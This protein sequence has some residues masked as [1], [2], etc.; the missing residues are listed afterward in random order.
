M[1]LVEY[2]VGVIRQGF[3]AF[4]WDDVLNRLLFM[5]RSFDRLTIRFIE[6]N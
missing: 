3:Y 1:Y 5:D 6:D 4:T 2:K